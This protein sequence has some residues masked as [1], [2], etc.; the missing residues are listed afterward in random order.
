MEIPRFRSLL[1]R[2]LIIATVDRRSRIRE[3]LHFEKHGAVCYLCGGL[4][5]L[6][7]R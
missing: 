4:I 1:L 5:A 3:V 6:T 7:K 2:P